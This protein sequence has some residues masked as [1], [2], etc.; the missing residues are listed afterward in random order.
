MGPGLLLIP[1]IQLLLREQSQEGEAA[2]L[3]ALD[4]Q[5]GTRPHPLAGHPPVC[6]PAEGRSPA[7]SWG[8]PVTLS[9][10]REVLML[11]S[12]LSG[13]EEDN[14]CWGELR[15]WSCPPWIT[16]LMHNPSL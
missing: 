15:G 1:E 6:A 9:L 5:A 13:L 14:E 16:L 11:F 2:S 7:Q 4:I 3:P 12:L 10:P 8:T